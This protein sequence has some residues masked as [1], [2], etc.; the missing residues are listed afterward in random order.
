[1][2]DATEEFFTRL[3]GR[4]HEPL[5]DKVTGTVAFHL[6]H[7]NQD[8]DWLVTIDHGRIGVQ[9]AISPVGSARTSTI[10][11]RPGSAK[12]SSIKGRSTSAR[13]GPARARSGLP[14]ADSLISTD[15]VL[16]DQITNGQVNVLA[17]VLRGAVTVDGDLELL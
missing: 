6:M 17:A 15:R 8:D 12:A 10:K 4:G 13:P 3:A 16:F 2:A 5:L 7:G 9:H 11:G 1:M 14:G